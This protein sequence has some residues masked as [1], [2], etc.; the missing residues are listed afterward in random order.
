MPTI[1]VI[2]HS[3]PVSSSV[4]RGAAWTTDSPRSI[5]PPGSAKLPLSVRRISR[6]S[7]APSAMYSS[8]VSARESCV[9]PAA[10]V[11]AWDAEQGFADGAGFRAALSNDAFQEAEAFQESYL[12]A[13]LAFGFIEQVPDVV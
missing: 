11:K 1:P 10:G 12:V 7:P 8:F 13:D 6:M 3:I 2:A 9:T 4:S 5:A